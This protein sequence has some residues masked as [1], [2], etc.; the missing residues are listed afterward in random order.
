M[1]TKYSKKFIIIMSVNIV[2][3]LLIAISV[4]YAYFVSSLSS[5]EAS[6][7]LTGGYLSV[8]VTSTS[9]QDN[10]LLPINAANVDTSENA[11]RHEFSVERS[12]DS[13]LAACYDVKM[14]VTNISSSLV[15]N[16]CTN[17][18]TNIKCGQ[19]LK[20]KVEDLNDNTNYAIGTF[21][22]VLSTEATTTT[23]LANQ[24]LAR[25]QR[26]AN[27]YKV[28]IWL[29]NDPNT[30]INQ[31]PMLES[32]PLSMTGYLSIV[33]TSCQFNLANNNSS[34]LVYGAHGTNGTVTSSRV[35]NYGG[36]TTLTVKPNDSYKLAS[37]SCT[38]GYTISN[39][40]LDSLDQQTVT[41]NNNNQSSDTTCTFTFDKVSNFAQYID[42]TNSD[43][44][45]CQNVY[46]ALNELHSKF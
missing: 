29:E 9:F 8:G 20:Y 30:N 3:V 31:M 41:I 10:E 5:T 23:I 15:S 37:G 14:T 2:L 18:G 7:N 11:F 33:G 6:I 43:Y 16:N 28:T 19:F 1:S 42:Y 35:I 34:W 40:T 36:T 4:T 12:S 26:T 45:T 44:T 46:C 32:S 22:N 38:N 17:D 21:E 39:M 27:D 13:T 25:N 24:K